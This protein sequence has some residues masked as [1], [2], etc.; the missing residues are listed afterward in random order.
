MDIAVVRDFALAVL[1]YVSHHLDCGRLVRLGKV[2]LFFS[3]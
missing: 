3:G 1:M 2:G